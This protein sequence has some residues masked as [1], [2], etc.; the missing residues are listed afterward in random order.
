MLPLIISTVL[1]TTS[2][3][4]HH[5]TVTNYNTN[6]TCIILDLDEITITVKFTGKNGTVETD[7]AT[8]NSTVNVTGDCSSSYGNRT[9]QKLQVEFLPSGNYTPGSL[10][11]PWKMRFIFG[12]SEKSSAFMLLNYSLQ[13]APFPGMNSSQFYHFT[14]AISDVDF[15]ARETDAFRCSTTDLP[16]SNNSMIEIKNVRAIAFA[17]LDKPEFEK[18]QIYEQCQLDSRTSDIVPIVVGA[19]LVGLVVI[20][21]VAY[22]IGRARAKRQG[23]ASV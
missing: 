17:Q 16:L 15:Q 19:C 14:K 23:Y 6:K 11:K 20:V 1:F 8:I 2:L 21:L 7:N 18:Q 13:T 10:N 4:S 3:G 12:T 22:L 5:W 9:A